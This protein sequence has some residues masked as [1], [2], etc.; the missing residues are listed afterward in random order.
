[1]RIPTGNVQLAVRAALAAS[2]SLGLAR[3]FGLENPVYALLASVIVTDLSPAQTRKLASLRLVATVVG[4][5][6]GAMLSPMLSPVPWAVGL[7]VLVAMLLSMVLRAPEAAK[8]AGYT[9]GI[10]VL[11][12]GPER[13]SHATYRLIET[14]LGIV[15]A[16]LISLVP[17]LI[18]IDDTGD[19]ARS[20]P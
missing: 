8:V 5:L 4:A 2:V 15:V 10:V 17:K 19:P 9:C 3:L 6:C 11:S 20:R 7:S 12:Y 16:W 18:R 1:M 14:A 13:W